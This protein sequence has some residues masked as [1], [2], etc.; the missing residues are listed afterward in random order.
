[1]TAIDMVINAIF[2]GLG[3]AIGVYIGTKH[4]VPKIDSHIEN[5]K[6]RI[7]D[8][9]YGKQEDDKNEGIK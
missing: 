1:M 4:L 7:K 9:F 6:D 8:F 5:G 3:T 2:T